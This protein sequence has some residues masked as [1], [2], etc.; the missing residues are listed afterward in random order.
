[1]TSMAVHSLI[2]KESI[3]VSR[4]KGASIELRLNNFDFISLPKFWD[5]PPELHDH[6]ISSRKYCFFDRAKKCL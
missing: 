5:I 4:G 3:R 1:M 6:N 2:I